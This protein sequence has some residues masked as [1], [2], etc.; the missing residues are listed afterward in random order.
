MVLSLIITL[1]V[2]IGAPQNVDER[3]IYMYLFYFHFSHMTCFVFLCLLIS[4]ILYDYVHIHMDILY[5]WEI[6]SPPASLTNNS[7]Q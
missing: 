4:H 5:H 3:F 6:A 7:L 2:A 1:E